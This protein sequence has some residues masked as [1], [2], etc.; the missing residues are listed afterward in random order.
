MN[1][2][3]INIVLMVSILAAAFLFAIGY[4]CEGVPSMSIEGACHT[5]TGTDGAMN[6]LCLRTLHSSS[7]PDNKISTYAGAA[8]RAAVLTCDSTA[9]AIQVMLNNGSIDRR[10]RLMWSGCMGDIRRAQ[11]AL[12]TVQDQVRR[13]LFAHIRQEYVEARAAIQHCTDKLASVG[14]TPVQLH[15]LVEDSRVR[16]V[17]AFRLAASLMP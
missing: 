14:P 9:G 8:A 15:Y 7:P 11:Q 6:S 17:L 3:A 4:A 13:C 1:S 16:T 12:G 10:H 5:A 2:R